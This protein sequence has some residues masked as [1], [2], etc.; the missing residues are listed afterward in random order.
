M[1]TI[2]DKR[3]VMN[4]F[5]LSEI[6]LKDNREFLRGFIRVRFGVE[7]DY[8]VDYI[9]TIEE[10][11]LTEN[12]NITA[13]PIESQYTTTKEQRLSALVTM[14]KIKTKERGV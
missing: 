14:V 4:A 12:D 7:R 13:V 1:N 8:V 5:E 3:K 10:Y 9:G 11:R 2:F 6:A